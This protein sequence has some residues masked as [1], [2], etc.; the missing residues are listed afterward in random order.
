MARVEQCFDHEITTTTLDLIGRALSGAVVVE[1]AD[2]DDLDRIGPE[3][4]SAQVRFRPDQQVERRPDGLTELRSWRCG[5]W[6]FGEPGQ[7][8]RTLGQRWGRGANHQAIHDSGRTP[9]EAADGDLRVVQ[10]VVAA[11]DRLAD[12]DR[13]AVDR[14]NGRRLRRGQGRWSRGLHNLDLRRGNGR[15]EGQDDAALDS[16]EDAGLWWTR[17]RRA[18]LDDDRP[19]VGANREPNRSI[20]CPAHPAQPDLVRAVRHL[21]DRNVTSRSRHVGWPLAGCDRRCRLEQARLVD[22]LDAAVPTSRVDYIERHRAGGG[23]RRRADEDERHE[24]DVVH[25]PRHRLVCLSRA[26]DEQERPPNRHAAARARIEA[27]YD[28]RDWSIDDAQRAGSEGWLDLADAVSRKRHPRQDLEVRDRC[29]DHPIDVGRCPR[30]LAARFG[31]V[32]LEID[33]RASGSTLAGDRVDPVHD[34]AVAGGVV[35]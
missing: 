15:R 7:V 4:T 23:G 5:L 6:F 29:Q 9:R 11:L 13:L 25:V 24:A 10:P 19:A 35:R 8:I 26:V 32:R 2:R 17:P 30:R 20:A 33:H 34:E 31:R 28:P 22:D 12:R 16:N 3:R 21:A 18:V 1:M 27:R 14:R